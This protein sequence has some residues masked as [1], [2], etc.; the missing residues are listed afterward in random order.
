MRE[1]VKF[2]IL[3]GSPSGEPFDVMLSCDLNKDDLCILGKRFV[4]DHDFGRDRHFRFR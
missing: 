3:K 1:I 4:I 2:N